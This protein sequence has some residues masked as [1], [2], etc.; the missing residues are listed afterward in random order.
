MEEHDVDA[1]KVE[2]DENN[3]Q[4]AEDLNFFTKDEN[5]FWLC[6]SIKKYQKKS[7]CS[8]LLC[9]RNGRKYP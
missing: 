9:G 5:I 1:L 7:Q 6:M 8:F 4:M 3:P 2:I